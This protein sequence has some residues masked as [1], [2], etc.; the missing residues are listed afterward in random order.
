MIAGGTVITEGPQAIYGIDAT[1][2]RQEWS[3]LRDGPPSTPAVADGTVLF[4]DGAEAASSR[5]RAVD[6]H[7]RKDAWEVKLQ[8]VSRSGV[9]VDGG[10]AFV[11]DAE[12]NVYGVE[13]ATGKL[14]W[15][16]VVGGEPKGPLAAAD[17]RLFTVPL[18]HDFRTPVTA[19][20]VALDETDGGNA[21]GAPYTPQPASPFAS[22]AA[23]DDQT[24]VVV[25]PGAVGDGEVRGI[26]TRDGS[27]SWSGRVNGAVF[28]FVSTAVGDDAVYAADVT[29]G[30]HRI[31]PTGGAQRWQFQFNERVVHSSPVVVG[32][33]V[34]LGLSDG[35]IGVVDAGTGHLV[36]RSTA[37][38]G[39]IGSLAVSPD[40][41]VAQRS[42]A[43]GGLV[44]FRHDGSG[45][46]I[47]VGSPTIPRYGQIVARFAVAFVAVGAAILVPLRLVARRL[48]PPPL[49]PEGDGLDGDEI[50]DD[51]DVSDD[52]GDEG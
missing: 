34:I 24:V 27:V 39:P 45:A 41:I 50:D 14:D 44:A 43:G 18:A 47:D 8:A 46:L 17:G 28:P 4:T 32:D 49:E 35:S 2:G 21:W 25:S 48:G 52:G 36:W 15:R 3:V 9:T 22:L 1:T 16:V 42:G 11:A 7:T 23:A 31:E 30:L 20:V 6:L 5:L 40:L 13:V 10:R 26:S 51:E 19:S 29:G 38:S 12:G 33:H 37:P